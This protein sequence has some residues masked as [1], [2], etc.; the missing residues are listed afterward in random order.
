ME[1]VN[2]VSAKDLEPYWET[3]I[4]QGIE[5]QVIDLRKT[6]LPD[7]FYLMGHFSEY[8]VESLPEI[9]GNPNDRAFF[10][11]SLIKPEAIQTFA[12]RTKG[13]ISEFDNKNVG[14]SYH[15]NIDSGFGKSYS[16]YTCTMVNPTYRD[17]AKNVQKIL[18]LSPEGYGMLMQKIIDKRL[19]DIDDTYVIE[20][21]LLTKQEIINA[22]NQAYENMLKYQG[23]Q[24]EF[25]ILSQRPIAFVYS[26]T[27][28]FGACP[29]DIAKSPLRRIIIFP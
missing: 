12:G 17:V 6:K 8:N 24:N 26:A 14:Q 21:R 10:S 7:D 22:H 25:T 15:Y 20:G 9:L 4:I 23:E 1:V 11:N 18:N 19:C 16:N 29:I 3:Q 2:T 27:A 13:I 28:T 5:C